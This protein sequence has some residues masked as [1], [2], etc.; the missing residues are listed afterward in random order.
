MEPSLF[1]H[2]KMK[3]NLDNGTIDEKKTV[4]ERCLYSCKL[5]VYHKKP[6]NIGGKLCTLLHIILKKNTR[7]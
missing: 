5:Q 4:R 7:T 3:N 2:G 1:S 6:N